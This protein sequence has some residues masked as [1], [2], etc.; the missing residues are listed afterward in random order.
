MSTRILALF[1]V[2]LA[3]C[4]AP[5]I[6][7][8]VASGDLHEPPRPWA[9]MAHDARQVWM[10]DEVLPR[11]SALFTEHDPARYADFGCG[12]CHGPDARAH[13]FAMPSP[14]LPALYATGT[15]EQR[16][17]VTDYPDGVRF[18]FNRVVPTMQTLLGAP[19]YDAA[20]SQ[21]FSC[22]AC[23]PHAGDEG[24]TPIRLR[25]PIEDTAS[26]GET[27]ERSGSPLGW[28]P[29]TGSAHSTEGPRSSAAR[30]KA[31]ASK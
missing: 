2:V 31:R 27:A 23:H 7:P 18:M 17:M 19:D 16:Q 22:Y 15:A 20:T 9:S 24:T 29:G 6:E 11:M 21:G 4:G 12:S 26:S 30:A 25:A 13:Q 28:T 10:M 5:P 3:G 8:E 14:A 1:A